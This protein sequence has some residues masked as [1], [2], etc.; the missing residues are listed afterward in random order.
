MAFCMCSV[1]SN[2]FYKKVRTLV[3]GGV[4]GRVKLTTVP[5]GIRVVLPLVLYVYMYTQIS[6]YTHYSHGTYCM[7]TTHTTAHM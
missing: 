1:V 5:K 2:K 7:Y 3:L 6:S 4:A